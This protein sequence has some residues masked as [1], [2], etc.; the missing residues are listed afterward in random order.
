MNKI[1]WIAGF[2]FLFL[3][4]DS[5][6]QHFFGLSK[7]ET[8]SLARETGFYEDNM[9]VNKKFNYLKFVN[10]AGTKTLIVFFSEEDLA[11]HSRK[12]C[13]YSEFRLKQ[14]EFDEHYEKISENTWEY[15]RDKEI[16]IVTIEEKEWYF[17]VRVK[18]K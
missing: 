10:S 16:F 8:R 18:K 1:L 12:V 17:V 11:T 2:L 4:P 13:D 7:D 6:G 15:E 14:N 9:I 3:L 5:H